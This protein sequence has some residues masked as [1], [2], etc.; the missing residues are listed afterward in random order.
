MYWVNLDFLFAGKFQINILPL[1]LH[2][3]LHKV[4]ES[5]FQISFLTLSKR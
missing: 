2:S 1:P 4:D 3:V 5:A